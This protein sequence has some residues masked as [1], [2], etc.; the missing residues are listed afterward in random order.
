M[1]FRNSAETGVQI[2]NSIQYYQIKI[3]RAAFKGAQSPYKYIEAFKAHLFL[4]TE[5]RKD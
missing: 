4:S 3:T 2:F 1:L 5:S